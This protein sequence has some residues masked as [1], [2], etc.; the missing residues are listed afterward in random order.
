MYQSPSEFDKKID[1]F[2]NLNKNT[3]N[4]N[5]SNS[6][7]SFLKISNNFYDFYKPN[8][9]HNFFN[10]NNNSLINTNVKIK[11]NRS[12]KND[13]D[14]NYNYNDFNDC[15]AVLVKI[16]DTKKNNIENL[17]NINNNSNSLYK[18]INIS[19]R[20]NSSLEK[21]TT[22]YHSKNSCSNTVL[23]TSSGNYFNIFF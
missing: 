12:N 1:K 19:N 20:I 3:N 17:N 18:K 14:N 6:Y 2:I 7:N 9:E 22:A 8:L 13:N 10:N 15:K 5:I 16:I 23:N 11:R 21:C 4:N